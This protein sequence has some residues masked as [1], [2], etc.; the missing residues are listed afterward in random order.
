PT[1]LSPIR[2]ASA[3][4]APRQ[5]GPFSLSPGRGFRSLPMPGPVDFDTVHEQELEWLARRR[6]DVCGVP[7]AVPV[8]AANPPAGAEERRN[9]V[10][11]KA[12]KMDLAGL[13]FPGG[14][15]RSATFNLGVLQGLASLR[16]LRL[17][18][19]LSTVSGG[20][21]IGGWLA[22]WIKREGATL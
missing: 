6:E 15:I 20:G 1:T 8:A 2:P 13:A 10:R 9:Q 5:P 21:F 22:A 17:F 19:Y 16:L 14:G 7:P 18:D 12:L 4:N 3:T 11:D